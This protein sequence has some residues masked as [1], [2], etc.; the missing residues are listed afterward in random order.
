[1]VFIGCILVFE[2]CAILFCCFFFKRGIKDRKR[3]RAL[4]EFVEK[5]GK[6]F[7]VMDRLLLW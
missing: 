2:G 7:V 1:M 5:V 3:G 6:A 4:E